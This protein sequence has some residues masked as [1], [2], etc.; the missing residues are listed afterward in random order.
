MPKP[1]QQ[2]R[3]LVDPDIYE[4]WQLRFGGYASVAWI[5]ETGMRAMLEGAATNPDF[6][7]MVKASM[8]EYVHKSQSIKRALHV[9]PSGA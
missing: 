6:E 7:E 8:R 2:V 9:Q 1:R 4:A 5:M 3:T